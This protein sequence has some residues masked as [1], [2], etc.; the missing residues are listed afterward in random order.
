MTMKLTPVSEREALENFLEAQRIGLIRKVE[1][2]SDE[3]ARRAPTAS[4]LSLLGLVKH[5]AMWEQRW[6]QVVMAGQQAPDRWPEVRPEPDDAEFIVSE[7]DTLSHWIRVY[8]GQIEKSNAI[9]AS[10]DLDARCA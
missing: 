9:A 7:S 4:S 2:V 5:A 6:F 8:R 1:G 10:M 3:L